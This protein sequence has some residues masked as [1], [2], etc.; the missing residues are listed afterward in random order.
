MIGAH[1]F[2]AHDTCALFRAFRSP[3]L[4]GRSRSILQVTKCT[5]CMA[6]CHDVHS[7][8]SFAATRSCAIIGCYRH[9]KWNKLGLYGLNYQ[10]LSASC[11]AIAP[12]SSS[13][14]SL[15]TSLIRFMSVFHGVC[16]NRGVASFYA[17]I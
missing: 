9:D 7:V 12:S 2:T 17:Q 14:S 5:F 16:R 15:P 3:A 4:L 1:S 10:L 11:S 13:S 8:S 6:C